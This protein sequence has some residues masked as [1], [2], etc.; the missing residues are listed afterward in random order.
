MFLHIF[1]VFHSFFVFFCFF[2]VFSV[3]FCNAYLNPLHPKQCV[4]ACCLGLCY[5]ILYFILSFLL[6]LFCDAHLRQAT[7]ILNSPNS[8]SKCVVWAYG[9][10]VS[11]LFV[12]FYFFQFLL[13]FFCLFLMMLS[14]DNDL[15][16]NLL[17]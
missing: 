12:Y 4:L 6:I 9:M 15:D 8:T 16:Q 5:V 1:F 17:F 3:Q 2:L 7:F 13:V 10:F 11:L 14:Q